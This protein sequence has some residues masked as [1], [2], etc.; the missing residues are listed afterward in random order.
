MYHSN[1]RKEPICAISDSA[2]AYRTHFS[3][4][5]EDQRTI[6]SDS[7]TLWIPV[8][9]KAG[10]ILKKY[11]Q[12]S[13]LK[14][15]LLHSRSGVYVL[16][17]WTES[18]TLP[19]PFCTKCLHLAKFSI[20]SFIKA[21]IHWAWKVFLGKCRLKSQF[22]SW[23]LDQLYSWKGSQR[24]PH[25]WHHYQKNLALH[26]VFR[27]RLQRIPPHWIPVSW[28]FWTHSK[29]PFLSNWSFIVSLL[30]L[31]LSI[32]DETRIRSFPI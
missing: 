26:L 22:L 14:Q 17:P 15:P 3:R 2:F 8:W 23:H 10:K 25:I 6:F 32:H 27:E 12:V 4:S 21:T 31:S 28:F 19:R 5:C 16:F 29:P 18:A 13:N 20:F 9:S 7:Y 11:C 1:F 24:R 30:G